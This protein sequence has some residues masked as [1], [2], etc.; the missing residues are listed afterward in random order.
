MERRKLE[1]QISDMQVDNQQSIQ[2]L[3]EK[4]S[5]RDSEIEELKMAIATL[6]GEKIKLQVEIDTAKPDQ[7]VVEE[8]QADNAVLKMEVDTVRESLD[9]MQDEKLKAEGSARELERQLGVEMGKQGLLQQQIEILDRQVEG[10]QLAQKEADAF[11]QERVQLE[12]QIS[13]LQ[14]EVTKYKEIT[15][16]ASSNSTEAVN[17]MQTFME[18][19]H[20][21]KKEL[22]ERL[23]MAE[24]AAVDSSARA[25]QQNELE[26]TIQKLNAQLNKASATA[27]VA[28]RE[29]SRLLEETTKSS[30]AM[31]D[32]KLKRDELMKDKARLESQLESHHRLKSESQSMHLRIQEL[33]WEVKQQQLTVSEVSAATERVQADNHV[34]EQQNRAMEDLRASHSKLDRESLQL[35]ED[36]RA[37]KEECRKVRSEA[38]R[39]Q[40][41]RPLVL[42]LEKKVSEVEQEKTKVLLELQALSNALSTA[43]DSGREQVC[44][45]VCVCVCGCGYG[46]GCGCVL[47]WG[48]SRAWRLK[49]RTRGALW[50]TVPHIMSH[51]RATPFPSRWLPLPLQ[52][53]LP[54]HIAPARSAHPR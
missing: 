18:A 41:N 7:H 13:M 23:K 35:K 46:C 39:Q 12:A 40:E 9:S 26:D 8:L 43:E 20:V 17:K 24:M 33:E 16:T 27:S 37:A 6:Q 36:L 19:L 14:E 29:N 31:Q 25:K 11:K 21:E 54:L 10:L 53:H 45:C 15:A 1:D 32:L 30:A 2:V 49:I 44:V 50:A 52:I 28:E 3:Q 4:L 5:S 38:S 47:A 42:Q 22:K 48:W 51:W 34:L